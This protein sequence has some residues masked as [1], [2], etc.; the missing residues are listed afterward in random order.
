MA[1]NEQQVQLAK[2]EAEVKWLLRKQRQ[3]EAAKALQDLAVLVDGLAKD[4]PVSHKAHAGRLLF[5]LGALYGEMGKHEDA[6]R[7]FDA[8]ALAFRSLR[9]S[10]PDRYG[11]CLGVCLYALGNE[12]GYLGDDRVLAL[13]QQAMVLLGRDMSDIFT[14]PIPTCSD[15]LDRDSLEQCVA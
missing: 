14:Y 11:K 2:R 5:A 9:N 8:A 3:A 1:T 12:L 15:V 10:A 6:S 7:A 13:A 4:D